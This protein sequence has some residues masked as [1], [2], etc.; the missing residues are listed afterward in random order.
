MNAQEPNFLKTMAFIS[1]SF[2]W[3]TT[4]GA[5]KVAVETIPPFTMAAARFTIFGGVLLAFLRLQG[6][7]WPSRRDWW[8]F[9]WIG[10]LLLS[11]AN[12]LVAW[13][14][15]YIDSIFAAL[16]V[17]LSPLLFVGLSALLGERIPRMG[18]LGMITG[19]AG[20]V[21]LC[22]PG[23]QGA[24]GETGLMHPMFWWAA[25]ALV[26]SPLLWAVGSIYA[27]RRPTR[28][29]HMMK[30]AGQNLMAG[31]VAIPLALLFGE[32][33][34]HGLPSRESL[35]ALAWLMVVGSG[36]GYIAYIYCLTH[37]P[38]H[39]TASILYINNVIA[40]AVGCLVLGEAFTWN[41]AAGG[42]TILVGVWLANSARRRQPPASDDQPAAGPT[43]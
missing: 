15:K 13:A 4:F 20:V 1:A 10:I 38:A 2:A 42:A 8:R 19:F 3:G 21:L 41:L 27:V 22:A 35:L 26:L 23:L 37:L 6:M 18:W 7:A 34:Q 25:G 5:M 31:L 43:A 33:F 40:L 24:L 29:P 12:P 16:M 32:N 39:R 11:L 36:V 28:C 17:S 30:I 14:V 9:L